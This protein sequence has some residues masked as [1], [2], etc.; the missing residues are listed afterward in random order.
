MWEEVS[1]TLQ[2]PGQAFE[3]DFKMYMGAEH[4]RNESSGA[5]KEWPVKAR[6]GGVPY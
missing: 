2:R 1:G 6:E 4:A 3:R 5:K